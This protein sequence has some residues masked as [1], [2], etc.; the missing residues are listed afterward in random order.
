[1]QKFEAAEELASKPR[2]QLSALPTSLLVVEVAIV[3]VES[4]LVGL[5]ADVVVDNGLLDELL[6]ELVVTLL[7]LVVDAL[8]DEAGLLKDDEL[9]VEL[10]VV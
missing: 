10:P 7:V 5:L 9:P 4:V 1:M 2:R 8:L 6:D 3:N